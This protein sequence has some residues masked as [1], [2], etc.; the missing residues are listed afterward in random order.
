MKSFPH[1]LIL[2]F[3]VVAVS[4]SGLISAR[5]DKGT[6]REFTSNDGRKMK[7]V[8]VS[9]DGE[10]VTI[11]RSDGKLLTASVSKFS[12][13]DQEFFKAWKPAREETVSGAS[14][15]WYQWRGPGR[16][17]VS[18]ERGLNTDWDAKEPELLWRSKGFGSGMA[19]IAISKGKIF[20]LGKRRSTV[21]H[22]RDLKD[23]S[24]IW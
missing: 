6:V 14:N 4:G 19:S 12:V 9:V 18:K 24:E 5:A 8:L 3:L 1:Y 21:M 11:R 2:V 15:D 16:D 13:S 7:A 10:R 23:G 17:G 22:Y 20:T